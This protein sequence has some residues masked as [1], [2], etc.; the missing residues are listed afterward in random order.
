MNIK[1]VTTEDGIDITENVQ[2]MYDTLLSSLDWG[3]GMLDL[4]EMK[5]ILQVAV[6]LGMQMPSLDQTE[7][8]ATIAQEFPEHYG[9]KCEDLDYMMAGRRIRRRKWTV[10][11]RG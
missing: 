4:D 11:R 10:T 5:A 3:S 2:I 6:V 1:T 8:G 9:V 7:H